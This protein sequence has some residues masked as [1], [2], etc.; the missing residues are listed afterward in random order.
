MTD[1][2][3]DAA[4]SGSTVDITKGSG[5]SADGSAHPAEQP[6]VHESSRE[7]DVLLT[8]KDLVKHFPVKEYT[9]LFPKTLQTRAVDGVSFDLAK[10][11]TL[12]LVGESGCGKTTTGRLVTRL[13]EPT[14]GSIE[15][16]GREIADL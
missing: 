8:V 12:G 1:N 13:L 14:S 9:G 16:E 6:I 4:A 10:G 5:E 15:F 11:E 2:T 3:T 7:R